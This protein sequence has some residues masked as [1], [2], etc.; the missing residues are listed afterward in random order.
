MKSSS[1]G[2]APRGTRIENGTQYA[3]E[4]EEKGKKTK[5]AEDY[6]SMPQRGDITALCCIRVVSFWIIGSY[7]PS[8]YPTAYIVL[9]MK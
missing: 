4:K 5:F 2:H 6:R 3:D 8:E 9:D 7:Y 1:N